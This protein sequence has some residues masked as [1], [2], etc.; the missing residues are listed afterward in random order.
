MKNGSVANIGTMTIPRPEILKRISQSIAT[1]DAVIMQ[2]WEF[3]YYS[4]NAAWSPPNQMASMRNGSGDH[5]FIL[6]IQD[7][8]VIKGFC[9]ELGSKPN[10]YDS[11][12]QIFELPFLREPAFLTT[13]VSF[14]C[15]NS[16]QGWVIRPPGAFADSECANTLLDVLQGPE[17]YQKWAEGYYERLIPLPIV[18]S[19]FNHE[20]L[21]DRMLKELNSGLDRKQLA[22]DLKEIGYPG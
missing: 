9:H 10:C 16:G 12:P 20:R 11:L 6:F 19:V 15:W 2:D 13:D 7:E 5:Y 22:A 21:D 18:R 1:L 8:V 3:R 4:F 14:A 17:K